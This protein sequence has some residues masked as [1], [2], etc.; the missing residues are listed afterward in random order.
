[1]K[2]STAI[3]TGAMATLPLLVWAGLTMAAPVAPSITWY[4]DETPGIET[5]ATVRPSIRLQVEI[6]HRQPL[7]V[8]VATHNPSQGAA[9]LFPTPWLATVKEN[10]LPGGS[11][12]L[13]GTFGGI[14]L[15]WAT[16]DV[17]APVDLLVLASEEPL[18]EVEQWFGRIR[19]ASNS[20]FPDRRMVFSLPK[21]V[22]GADLPPRSTWPAPILAKAAQC[23]VPGK[24]GRLLPLP[25]R[26][27]VWAGCVKIQ[28]EG[29]T[30]P[31]QVVPKGLEE[32]RQAYTPKP[33]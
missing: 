17:L 4:L 7:Y 1:M 27:K 13:P 29:A 31:D 30:P 9:A 11:H 14:Q 5:F 25:G 19:Q 6:E 32:L 33:K 8:Y 12:R 23:V 15:A 22:S 2:R 16:P 28:V 21:D 20:V 3:R 10:P 24:H 18:A 26:A